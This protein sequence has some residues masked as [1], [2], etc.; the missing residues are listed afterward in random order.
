MRSLTSCSE[1]HKSGHQINPVPEI[2]KTDVLIG[3]VLI[4]IVVNH[5]D[6][7]PRC[8]QLLLEDEERN[9]ATHRRQLYSRT[10]DLLDRC[11]HLARDGQIHSCA[12]A[13][14][15]MLESDA[16]DLCVRLTHVSVRLLVCYEIALFSNMVDEPANLALRCH[17]F[18]QPH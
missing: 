4:I 17:A 6:T 10:A 1:S 14:V 5:R 15:A 11:N 16:G 2:L 3:G 18:D 13:I 7:D 8:A 12:R 9:A